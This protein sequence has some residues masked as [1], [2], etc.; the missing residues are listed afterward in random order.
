MQLLAHVSGLRASNLSLRY[1]VLNDPLYRHEIRLSPAKIGMIIDRGGDFPPD[2]KA[3]LNAFGEDMWLYRD[4]SK[5]VTTRAVNIYRG[6]KRGYILMNYLSVLGNKLNRAL[7]STTSLRGKGSPPLTFETRGS[8]S[9]RTY[10][11]FVPP[12]EQMQ[13]YRKCLPLQTGSR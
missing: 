11:S 1:D 13:S 12:R 4:D 3:S 5:R 9:L 2:I 7:D 10:T 8:N 6:D